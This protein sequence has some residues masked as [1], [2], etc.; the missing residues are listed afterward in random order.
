MAIPKGEIAKVI[1]SVPREMVEFFGD[2]GMDLSTL[3]FPSPYEL[4]PPKVVDDFGGGTAHTFRVASRRGGPGGLKENVSIL[5]LEK[6]R[7]NPNSRQYN[8][9]LNPFSGAMISNPAMIAGNLQISKGGQDIAQKAINGPFSLYYPSALWPFMR[10]DGKRYTV[11][12]LAEEPIDSEW[13][14]TKPWIEW[15]TDRNYDRIGALPGFQKWGDV[16]LGATAAAPIAIVGV[17]AFFTAPVWGPILTQ[18][19]VATTVAASKGAAELLVAVKDGPGN[20]VKSLKTQRLQDKRSSINRKK[21][22]KAMK[23]GGVEDL[24]GQIDAL[25]LMRK[26]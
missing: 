12:D 5:P 7:N 6:L 26:K 23:E 22:K 9:Y 2:L 13:L 4:L 14:G 3:N 8:D 24:L 1:A 10:D 18:R 20:I 19:V 17:I 11:M 21:A 16:A 15:A 25:K